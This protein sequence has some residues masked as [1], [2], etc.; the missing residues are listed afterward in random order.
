[1]TA[2]GLM[3]FAYKVAAEGSQDPVNQNAAMLVW[4][5]EILLTGASQEGMTAEEVLIA[6]AASYGVRTRGLA[7]VAP[8]ISDVRLLLLA[9]IEKV[10]LHARRNDLTGWVGAAGLLV[11]RLEEAL[12]DAP[13]IRV[14][15]EL[16]QP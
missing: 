8:L 10:I 15:R 12:P 4:Q 13:R 16:W 3:E 11:D 7:V 9:K 5:G 2:K 1:M 14:R 6:T